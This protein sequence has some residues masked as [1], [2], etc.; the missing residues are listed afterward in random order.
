MIEHVDNVHETPKYRGCY[1]CIEDRPHEFLDRAYYK[2]T[3]TDPNG[4]ARSITVSMPWRT[5]YG[6]DR[7]LMSL[8]RNSVSESFWKMGTVWDIGCSLHIELK[9]GPKTWATVHRLT[10]HPENFDNE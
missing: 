4:N 5:K 3:F 8:V 7:A 10:F 6:A 9:T 2:A 1:Y